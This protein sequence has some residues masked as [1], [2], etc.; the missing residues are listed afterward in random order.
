LG[1]TLT[2]E[3]LTKNDINALWDDR[4]LNH[5]YEVFGGMPKVILEAANNAIPEDLKKRLSETTT[6]SA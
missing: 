4:V 3:K 1:P 2:S 6:Y 5:A